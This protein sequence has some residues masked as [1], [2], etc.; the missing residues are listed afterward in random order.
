MAAV[1]RDAFH[2]AGSTAVIAFA[3][4]PSNIERRPS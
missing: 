4:D 3:V 1:E 2:A